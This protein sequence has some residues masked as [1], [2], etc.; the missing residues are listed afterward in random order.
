MAVVAREV[1]TDERLDDLEEH[2][3]NGFGE[4]KGEIREVKTEL[5]STR[6]ELKEG[7]AA[8]RIELKRE[9]GEVR[10]SIEKLNGRFD[11]LNF[12]LIAALLGL[13]ATHYL[14]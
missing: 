12:T 11:R 9:I 7:I 13:L 14:G 8:T 2:M 6:H 4:V 5:R 10:G 3:D 1:W